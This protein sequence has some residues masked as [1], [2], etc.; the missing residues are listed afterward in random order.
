VSER[1]LIPVTMPDG[2]VDTSPEA[3]QAYWE[4]YAQ[5]MADAS[6]HPCTVWG[7]GRTIHAE[8]RVADV[9]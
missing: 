8:P 4:T 1:Q 6:G 9:S 2:E 5:R 7:P 3:V